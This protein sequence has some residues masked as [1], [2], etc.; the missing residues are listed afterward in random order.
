M[1]SFGLSCVL[2][3]H[4]PAGKAYRFGENGQV[5]LNP[6]DAKDPERLAQVML[7]TVPSPFRDGKWPLHVVSPPW[8]PPG[9]PN[10]G[11]NPPLPT[12]A[13]VVHEQDF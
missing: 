13:G 8:E 7:T 11:L 12:G 5:F 1:R 4:V 6:D 10:Y 9:W 3:A 2:S